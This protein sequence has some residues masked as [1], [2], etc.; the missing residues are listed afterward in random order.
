[1]GIFWRA[2]DWK[3]YGHL[4]YFTGIWDSLWPFS[5]LC[6]HL[7]RVF[8]V[9]VLC[10]KKNL[11]ILIETNYIGILRYDRILRKGTKCLLSR[12]VKLKSNLLLSN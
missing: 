3:L 5:T 8:P 9:L 7:V 1:L 4:E 12:S 6:V 2:L 10:N 11:A